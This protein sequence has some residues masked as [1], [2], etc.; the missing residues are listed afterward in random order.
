MDTTVPDLRFSR[1]PD[2]LNVID[3]LFD[4]LKMHILNIPIHIETEQNWV[5]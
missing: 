5:R 4:V 3:V 1:S 2:T